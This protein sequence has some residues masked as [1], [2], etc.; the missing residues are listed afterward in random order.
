MFRLYKRAFCSNFMKLWYFGD[1]SLLYNFIMFCLFPRVTGE[2]VRLSRKEKCLVLLK[3]FLKILPMINKYVGDGWSWVWNLFISDHQVIT[4][5]FFLLVISLLYV[6]F[7]WRIAYFV[8]LYSIKLV[9]LFM[10]FC[11]LLYHCIYNKFVC[12]CYI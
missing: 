12:I 7:H 2:S 8:L 9:Y 11:S 1:C 4:L 10:P 6:E 5:L 3:P